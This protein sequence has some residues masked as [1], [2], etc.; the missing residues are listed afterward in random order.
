MIIFKKL[1]LIL[2]QIINKVKIKNY[3]I[4]YQIIK[5]YIIIKNS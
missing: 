3:K 2:I 4:L 1:I 5:Y